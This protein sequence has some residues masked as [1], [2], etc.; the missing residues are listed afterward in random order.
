[1]LPPPPPNTHKYTLPQN[2][3]YPGGTLSQNIPHVRE[4]GSTNRQVCP[5]F[6]RSAPSTHTHTHTHTHNPQSYVLHIF[7]A[8]AGEW[9][10]G[11][12]LQPC[13]AKQISHWHPTPPPFAPARG[14]C[15]CEPREPRNP[16]FPRQTR[17]SHFRAPPP[18]PPSASERAPPPPPPPPPPACIQQPPASHPACSCVW[19]LAGG[20]IPGRSVGL[21]SGCTILK[22]RYVLPPQMVLRT[23]DVENSLLK[24]QTR[25]HTR[26]YQPAHLMGLYHIPYSHNSPPQPTSTSRSRNRRST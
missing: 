2:H 5:T 16:Q 7:L 6:D 14:A 19:A 26:K 18:P 4:T 11:R 3:T 22:C 15:T 10:Q 17:C 13:A 9:A 20:R 21:C 12:T 23:S 25:E 8:L 1:M 24:I